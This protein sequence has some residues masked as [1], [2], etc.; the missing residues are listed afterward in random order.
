MACAQPAFAVFRC[1]VR[2]HL[3]TPRAAGAGSGHM[4]CRAKVDPARRRL[5]L[6]AVDRLSTGQLPD[7]V[8][9]ATPGT[10]SANPDPPPSGGGSFSPRASRCADRAVHQERNP[11]DPG[12]AIGAHR[13]PPPDRGPARSSPRAGLPLRRAIHHRRPG[14]RRSRPDLAHRRHRRRPP[15]RR[16]LRRR[17]RRG[18]SAS[19]RWRPVRYR[20]AGGRAG[21]PPRGGVPVRGVSR[22][23]GGGG[24]GPVRVRG[25]IELPVRRGG[26][27]DR[28]AHE[29][30]PTP[31]VGV[32][33]VGGAR[34]AA[35]V[36]GRGTG[37]E[38]LPPHPLHPAVPQP[39]R[40]LRV[41][42]QGILRRGALHLIFPRP[43]A[44]VSR[45]CSPRA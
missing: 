13:R 14:P 30:P 43:R 23:G 42:P 8:A 3:P 29:G 31:A 20:Y 4:A 32:L 45:G 40:S 26:A 2:L 24:H 38:P 21:I 5:Q 37:R 12:D 44:M 15:G 9:V 27:A 33:R 41:P 1:R 7:A 18:R 22:R 11:E 35:P 34:R 28:G 25:P 36:G 6:P 39:R 10:I 17:R 16:P 19:L